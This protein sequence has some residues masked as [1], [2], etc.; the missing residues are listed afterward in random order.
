MI[1]KIEE[2]QHKQL[3]SD[4]SSIENAGGILKGEKVNIDQE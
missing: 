4:S 1:K 3:G 2:T